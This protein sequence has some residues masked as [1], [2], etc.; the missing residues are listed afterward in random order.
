VVV[1]LAAVAVPY[2]VP[3]GGVVGYL[4]VYGIPIVVVSVFFGK[5]ILSRAA[6]NNQEG[7]KYGLGLFSAFYVA[8]VVISIAALM[9]ITSMYPSAPDILQKTNPALD[10]SASQAW[11]MIAISMLVIGPAEEYLFRGFMYGGL[12]SVTKGKHWLP[13]AIISSL[14][15]AFA[16]GYYVLTYGVASPVYIIQLITF[17]LA[18]CIAY[19]WSKGNIVAIATVHGLNDAIGFLGVATNTTIRLA[20]QS[21]FIAIGL[22][23]VLLFITQKLI[24]K[25]PP[26]TNQEPLQPQPVPVPTNP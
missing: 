5:Q 7:F 16:H 25:Q 20:A 14:L 24:L 22:M 13:M 17:G 15:F 18:M 26:Q 23:F 10:V 1:I 3:L 8:G 21:I 11:L 9:I 12:L 4:V 2:F 6:K 19:Y